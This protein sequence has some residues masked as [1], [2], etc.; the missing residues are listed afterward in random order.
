MSKLTLGLLPLTSLET[1]VGVDEEVIRLDEGQHVLDAV[2][3][4][5]L[6]G[7]TRRVDVIDTGADVV[8]VA[9]FLEGGEELHVALRGFDGNDIG[10]ETL[11]RREDVVEVG[12]TEVRVGLGL[13]LNTSSRQAEGIDSPGEV[14]VPVLA[15]ERQLNQR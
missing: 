13:V 5:L 4:L 6:A 7:D 11:D 10:V 15:A 14:S 12:V 8:L 2:L 9:E 3:D 1:T